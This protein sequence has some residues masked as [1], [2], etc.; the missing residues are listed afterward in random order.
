[1]QVVRIASHRAQVNIATNVE[2][3]TL[4]WQVENLRVAGRSQLQKLIEMKKEAGELSLDN[5]RR[6]HQLWRRAEAEVLA[7]ADV[8]CV[9]CIGAADKR[10]RKMRFQRVW[11]SIPL[12]LLCPLVEGLCDYLAASAPLD[13]VFPFHIEICTQIN[14]WPYPRLEQS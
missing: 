7:E 11:L 6:L 13:I 5:E 8:V 3:L 9:T 12:F 2:H 14:T 10:L 1:M 4:H